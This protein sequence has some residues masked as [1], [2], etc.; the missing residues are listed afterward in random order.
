MQTERRKYPLTLDLIY[1]I[2]SYVYEDIR[3]SQSPQTYVSLAKL[4]FW[5]LVV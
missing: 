1:F 3:D 2:F 4:K 5:G